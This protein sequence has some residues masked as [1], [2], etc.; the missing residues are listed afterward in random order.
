MAAVRRAFRRGEESDD[1]KRLLAWCI[2]AEMLVAC[3]I[4]SQWSSSQVVT[5]RL[6][7]TTGKFSGHPAHFVDLLEP[8]GDLV[9]TGRHWGQRYRMAADDLRREMDRRG[10]LYE[11]L[12]HYAQAL[13]GFI[14]QSTACNAVHSV[15]RRLARWLLMAQDRMHWNARIRESDFRRPPPPFGPPTWAQEWIHLRPVILPGTG[16][17]RVPAAKGRHPIARVDQD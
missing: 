2:S 1:S 8:A 14:M 11:L 15:E 17:K 4:E 5:V 13:V 12:T 6:R 3:E 16:R 7:R 9:P 10:P